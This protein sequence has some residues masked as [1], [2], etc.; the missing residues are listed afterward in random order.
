[1]SSKPRNWTTRKVFVIKFKSNYR[2]KVKFEEYTRI[3]RIVTQVSSLSIWEY[4][5][6]GEPLDE[7][8]ERVPDEFYNWVKNTKNELEAEFSE[9][10]EQ[11][12]TDYKVLD[13]RKE[14]RCIF[15]LVSIHLCCSKC[16][17]KSRT[18]K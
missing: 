9:I 7:I 2:L 11:A 6:S 17:T 10:E 1:M 8:L 3:H 13:S 18:M 15:K 14:L 16:W 12:K 5:K 4:L